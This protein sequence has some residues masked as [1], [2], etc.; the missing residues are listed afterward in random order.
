MKIKKTYC[1]K[2]NL[3]KCFTNHSIRATAVTDA[4]KSGLEAKMKPASVATVKLTFAQ[5]KN[6]GNPCCKMRG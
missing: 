1:E 6:D 5:I 4:S 2:Q 3:A